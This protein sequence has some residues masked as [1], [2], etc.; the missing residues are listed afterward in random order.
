[1][2]MAIAWPL[3][4]DPKNFI[5]RTLPYLLQTRDY[6]NSAVV[7]NGRY[8]GVPEFLTLGI[9]AVLGIMV[10][11]SLWLLY[12]YCREDR[13]FFFATTS[14]LI[15]TAHWLLGSLGQMYYSMMLFPLLMTVV[16]RN[17]LLR[18]W[19]AWLAIYGFMN[20]DRW[21]S[22][23]WIET[24]RA[25]DYLR[26]TFGWALLI[27]VIFGVLVGRWFAARTEGRLDEGIE[28]SYLLPTASPAKTA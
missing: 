12:R 28:P 8:Y 20:A 14:G 7:G 17:S 23:R 5:D 6:F 26:T 24:G 9:R 3:S 4:V 22:G 19:P 15:L 21:L 25:L 16:L 1:V 2:M 27:V 11:V 18:N 10:L 13:L